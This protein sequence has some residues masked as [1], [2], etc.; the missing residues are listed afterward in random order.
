MSYG[1]LVILSS[2]S[3][4]GKTTILNALRSQSEIQFVYSISATTRTPRTG[5]KDGRDYY[6]L[7]ES[8]FHEKIE[9]NEFFE[10]E[11]VHRYYYGTPRKPIEDWLAEG[12][13]V[14]LD[15]DVNGGLQVKQA[16][17][18]KTISLFIAPPTPEVLI[19]RLKNRKTDSN[20]EIENR[21]ERVPMEMKKKDLFDFVIIN[22]KIDT[23]VQQVL[24]IIKQYTKS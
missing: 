20:A 17:P 18:E 3:G 16:L 1:L 6:F 13:I 19:E 22:D 4:G 12:K 11:H 23:C 14:L 21:L 8:S 15:I 10:W 7:T 2:P 24:D 5:E 9:G